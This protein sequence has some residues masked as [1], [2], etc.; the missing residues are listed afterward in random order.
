LK[1]EFRQIVEALFFCPER[2]AGREIGAGRRLGTSRNPR[3][4]LKRNALDERRSN[5][6]GG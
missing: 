6:L 4:R 1:K 3:R 2:F 5:E